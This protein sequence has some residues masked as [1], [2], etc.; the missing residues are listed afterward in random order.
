MRL[1]FYACVIIGLAACNT[2]PSNSFKLEGFIEGAEDSEI[3][4]LYYDILKNNE[5]H[6]IA[7]TAKII[8]GKFLFEGKIDELTAASLKF[9]FPY[10][11]ISTRI[12]LEPTTMELRINKNQPY[13][14]KLSGTKVEKENL[15]LRK[16]LEAD[17]KTYHEDAICMNDILEQL[18]LY[19]NNIPVRDSLYN[20]FQYIQNQKRQPAFK[21]RI[22]TYLGFSLKHNTYRIVPDLIYLLAKSE[23][24]PIDTLKYI[25]NNLPK[26]LKTGL[27][28]KLAYKQIEYQEKYLES[29]RNS[30]IGNP[31]PSFTRKDPSGK[32]IRL[33]DFKNKSFVLLDFWA[34]WC[35]PCIA[36]IPCLKK[37]YERYKDKGLTIINISLDKDVSNWLNAINQYQLETCP[38]ILDAKDENNK[39]RINTDD[40]SFLYNVEAIPHYILIDKQGKIIARW[41][42]LN[43]EQIVELDNILN[44]EF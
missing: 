14:Y 44:S 36:E 15:E 32:T 26:P 39:S 2:I 28:G 24:I 30:S 37:V 12:Y 4:I 43:N 35:N 7:D 1:F 5:L 17:E 22:N 25:Y 16:E 3:L 27:M 10:V 19:S 29:K 31:A 21:K 40:I 23:S 11:V 9:D 38:Q 8:N 18:H 42:F 20:L 41:E 13:A 33:S 6:S 34:S